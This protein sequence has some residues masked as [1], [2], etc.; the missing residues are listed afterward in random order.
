LPIEKQNEMNKSCKKALKYLGYALL[1]GLLSFLVYA[2]WFVANF[3]G[4]TY[5]KAESYVLENIP[6]KRFYVMSSDIVDLLHD[7]QCLHP[8]YRL[9]EMNSQGE[10]YHKFS[11]KI[12][13]RSD[14]YMVH[15]YFEDIDMTCSC[16]TEVSSRNHTL[17]KLY[18]VSE[19]K[20]FDSCKRINNYREISRKE[21]KMIKKK[22]ET[23]ILDNLG[24]K[25]KHK[26]F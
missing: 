13:N 16:I 12:E 23:E 25:W 3:H 1:I 10:E 14:Q 19:G 2:C 22:F 7:F 9:M 6:Q 24:V 20:N 26:M 11:R 4:D 8:Q 15:F 5:G 17:V 18:A 21:N